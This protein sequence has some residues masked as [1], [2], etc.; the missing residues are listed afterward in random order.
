[1]FGNNANT[2]EILEK[3]TYICTLFG[4]SAQD[5]FSNWEAFAFTTHHNSNMKISLDLLEEL[6]KYIQ[7][8]ITE[9]NKI[10]NNSNT[11][12]RL[13]QKHSL[14][15]STNPNG[16]NDS[17][18][19]TS[20]YQI[21]KRK[22]NVP[23]SPLKEAQNA[24][25]SNEVIESFNSHIADKETTILNK[26]IK[27][28]ASFN[29]K[30][31]DYRTMNLKLLEIADYYD[32]RIDAFTRIVADSYNLEDAQ[33][34][35]PTRQSQ[36]E[37]YTVGRIVP[38]SPLSSSS[39]LNVDSLFLET[40]RSS[41]FGCR[42]PLDISN[43][44]KCSFFSGQ[45]VAFRGINSTGKSFKVIENL[46]LPYLGTASYNSN[47]IENFA[48][49]IG[50]DNLK[51]S[52]ASGPYHPKNSLNFSHLEN[53]VNNMNQ[54]VK[55]DILIL[56]GPFIDV[57]AVPTILSNNF[58]NSG[59][60]LD[61]LKSL[62]D[63]FISFVAPILNE[64]QC[65][66]TIIIP[67]SSDVSNPH[68]SYPQSRFNR[69]KLG[70]TKNFKCFPNPSIFNINELSFGISTADILKDLKDVPT[71]DANTNRIARII[72]H[73]IQQRH[74]YPVSPS[75]TSANNLANEI[76]I[77]AS[78]L[79]LAEFDDELPDIFIFPSVVKPFAK[80]VKNALIINPGSLVRPDGSRGTYSLMQVKTPDSGDMETI[81]ISADDEEEEIVES[82]LASAWKRAKVDIFSV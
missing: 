63:L 44:S 32:E 50:D 72:E 4:I 45:I 1:M 21:K 12:L 29:P 42:I 75:P 3:C 82:Y 30:K 8:K 37:I 64:I 17:G 56:M 53:F 78:Y 9:E 67:H 13:N 73:V 70:L 25:G 26:N 57:N 15:S 33:F 55:P 46:K 22:L 47:E 2:P 41:G 35:D 62:D 18:A 71:K 80:I 23:S 27:L 52:I 20:S 43:I 69:K 38:D 34:S 74:F 16:S 19:N 79:G 11:S 81:K 49:I 58:F 51:I 65:Q 77:E 24:T 61:D 14:K 54:N 5:L 40:S 48:D 6:Q 7:Q 59:D 68:T 76:Q 60:D 66:R 36:S 31:Y 10:S 39:D 28:M